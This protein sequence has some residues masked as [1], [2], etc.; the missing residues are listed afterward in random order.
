MEG[1]SV[2]TT[3]KE[4]YKM[5]WT[6]GMTEILIEEY[7]NM[8]ADFR[9]PHKKQKALQRLLNGVLIFD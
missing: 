2:L 5:S 3:E 6:H 1:Y 8:V 4:T 7:Q 9:N